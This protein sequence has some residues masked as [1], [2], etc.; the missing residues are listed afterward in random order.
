MS[1]VQ[2]GS[3]I[4]G[5]R[6][7]MLVGSGSFGS[8]WRARHVTS[9]RVVALK[10][11]TGTYSTGDAAASRAAIE[12]LAAS[13][14]AAS[15][16][17]VKVLDG[18]VEPVPFV[19]ME[20]IEGRNLRARIDVEGPL[21]VEETL[22]IGRAVAEA[23]RVLNDARIIHRDVKPANVM[24]TAQGV[25][26]LTDFGIA[27]IVGYE[28]VTLTGVPMS[29]A[30]TAPEAWEENRASH[31]SDL[32]ALGIMMYECLTGRP[33]FVGTY[34]QVYQ[35]HLSREPD[36]DALPEKL[37]SL[38]ELLRKCL[39]KDP[40]DR[41]AD[42]AAC[43]VLIEQAQ[44][45]WRERYGSDV[46]PVAPEPRA[47]GPWLRQSP[48][49]SLPGAW[50]CIHEQTAQGATVEVVSTDDVAL[51]QSLRRAVDANAPIVALGAER[52]LGTNRLIL[53]PGEAWVTP[54]AG[55]FQFW[56]RAT[57]R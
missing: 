35:A 23:L 12:L 36:Y 41:P 47:F 25:P 46:P 50:L 37:P 55:Q 49:P 32:Y 1:D 15:P 42:A 5:Y 4:G 16:H 19:V 24:I 31:Y 53:R 56:L 29:P 30:Y 14:S 40:A 8:V 3:E 39:A 9:N 7:E 33:P 51:G 27:K 28:S 34:P 26:K 22:R 21:G 2:T 13:A 54:P 44:S 45:E 48:H 57:N 18:G 11:L 6:L 10:V 20:Y 38:F 52:L 43:L 17:V